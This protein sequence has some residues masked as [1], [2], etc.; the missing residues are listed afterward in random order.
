MELYAPIVITDEAALPVDPK[1]A[2][3]VKQGLERGKK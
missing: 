2:Q 1:Y 3:E